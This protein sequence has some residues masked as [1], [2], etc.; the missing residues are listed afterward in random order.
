MA[1]QPVHPEMSE[2]QVPVR[3]VAERGIRFERRYT[4]PRVHP[5]DA[6]EWELRDAVITNERGET[7]FEQRAVEMPKAWS[8]TATNVVVSKYF[9]GQIGTPQRE[10]SVRQLI[11]RVADTIAEWGRE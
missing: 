9:R 3:E 7:V 6:V 10:R 1:T 5:F 8:Q 11:G 2:G 4:T